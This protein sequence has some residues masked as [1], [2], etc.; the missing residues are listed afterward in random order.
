MKNLTIKRKVLSILGAVLTVVLVAALIQMLTV[1][2]SAGNSSLA[3]QED[4]SAYD[5]VFTG[6]VTLLDEPYDVVLKGKDG[7]FTVDANQLKNIMDGTYTFT[8]GQGYT[9]V[10]RDSFGTNV[11]SQYDRDGKEHGFLYTL[12]MGSRGAG[13]LRLSRPD[14]GFAASA[15]P[16]NDLPAFA[17][18]PVWFG[19]VLS[20][21]A[22][23]S[24][25]A[26]GNF[27]IFCTG[28]EINVIS[29]TYAVEG[30]TYTLTAEDGRVVT[31]TID[32]ETGLPSFTMVVHR[33]A[34]E[35]YGAAADAETKFTLTVLTVD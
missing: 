32:E 13:T 7:S 30:N 10:F 21:S 28:G 22:V 23:C 12:D 9:F 27:Q 31:S 18:T 33:P 25:D 16:W 24:C 20:A 6:N 35:A 2:R 14:P 15:T 5:V 17:G 34:L 8:E 19:G 29:G 4:L 26:E 1:I 11:R 3:A